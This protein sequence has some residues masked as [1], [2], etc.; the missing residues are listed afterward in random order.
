MSW[1]VILTLF[2]MGVILEAIQQHKVTQLIFG[3]DFVL[4][5]LNITYNRLDIIELVLASF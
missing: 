4:C 1:L 5:I 2:C 3:V